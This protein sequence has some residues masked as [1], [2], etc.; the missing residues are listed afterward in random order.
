MLQCCR[1]TCLLRHC[2]GSSVITV[3]VCATTHVHVHMRWHIAQQLLAQFTC[4]A[5][6]DHRAAARATHSVLCA[7]ATPRLQPLLRAHTLCSSSR[8]L[9]MLCKRGVHTRK[10]VLCVRVCCECVTRLQVL[11]C[12][13]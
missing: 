12:A 7:A 8:R 11:R 3:R 6:T 4:F 2:F 5:H 9:S 13:V 10:H 1:F